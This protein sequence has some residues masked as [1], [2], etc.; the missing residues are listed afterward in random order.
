MPLEL[1]SRSH[2]LGY[3]GFSSWVVKHARHFLGLGHTKLID[4]EATRR[5]M[6]VEMTVV[7]RQAAPEPQPQPQPDAREVG[8]LEGV[9]AQSRESDSPRPKLS[10]GEKLLFVVT[11]SLSRTFPV[12][13]MTL[14][15]KAI[16]IRC[17]ADSTV[18]DLKAK[19]QNCEGIPPDQ[20]RLVFKGGQLS[21][22]STVKELGISSGA[23]VHL[24]L[25]LRGGCFVGGTPV[26]MADG[27]C[28]PIEHVQVGDRVMTLSAGCAISEVI[29]HSHHAQYSNARFALEETAGLLLKQKQAS[30]VK[31]GLCYCTAHRHRWPQ[32]AANRT[33]R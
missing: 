4:A 12:R 25:R 6:F 11:A 7:Q 32:C 28:K 20:Q 10:S 24:V 22:T 16:N 1:I 3:P 29:P 8:E 23:T 30:S 5:G 14:T 31:H 13:V 9:T 18:A 17:L 27:T 19:I 21:D 26:A 33:S 15:G 2:F